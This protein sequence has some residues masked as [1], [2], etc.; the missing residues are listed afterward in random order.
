MQGTDL[1]GFRLS[2]TS[3]RPRAI[4]RRHPSPSI[5]CW[6]KYCRCTSM[7]KPA[8]QRRGFADSMSA[9]RNLGLRSIL[10]QI[11]ALLHTLRPVGNLWLSSGDS[12]PVFSRQTRPRRAHRGH[13]HWLFQRH[14]LDYF[15]IRNINRDRQRTPMQQRANSFAKKSSRRRLGQLKRRAPDDQYEL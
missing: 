3:V 1:P 15:V 14:R 13:T 10:L 11:N 6:T 2:P 4:V 9:H 7:T 5:R 12:R 8:A